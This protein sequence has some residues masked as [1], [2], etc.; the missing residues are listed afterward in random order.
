MRGDIYA[1]LKKK[2]GRKEGESERRREC[3]FKIRW[4]DK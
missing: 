2:K 1:I 4:R 3:K